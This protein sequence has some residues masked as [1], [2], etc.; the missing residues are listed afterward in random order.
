M[1]PQNTWYVVSSTNGHRLAE[2]Y[3]LIAITQLASK[4]HR[5]TQTDWSHPVQCFLPTRLLGG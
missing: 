3:M 1:N 5:T 2:V 4:A